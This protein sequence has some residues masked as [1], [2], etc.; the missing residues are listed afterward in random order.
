MVRKSDRLFCCIAGLLFWM[1]CAE[2]QMV[3]PYMQ[4][5]Y[6][7]YSPYSAQPYTPYGTQPYVS[8]S[9]QPYSQYRS[10][11]Y[12]SYYNYSSNSPY[13][14]PSTPYYDDMYSNYRL[15]RISPYDDPMRGREQMPMPV[16][17]RYQNYQ[18]PPNY[19]QLPNY[20]QFPNYQQPPRSPISQIPQARINRSQMQMEGA[21]DAN[22]APN[23]DDLADQNASDPAYD[24]LDF[25]FGS[26]PNPAYFPEN[27]LQVWFGTTPEADRQIRFRFEDD[28]VAASKGEYNHWRQTP[29]GTLAL[30]LL[31]D[32][33]T[34]R[35]YAD[36]PQKYAFD[37]MAKGLVLEAIQ[38]KEDLELYPIERAFLYLPL[39]H[40][41]DLRTQNLSV[42][43]YR[44]LVK[45]APGPLKDQMAAFLKYAQLHRDQIARFGRFPHRNAL[46]GRKSTPQ[47]EIF[48]KQWSKENRK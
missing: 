42:S 31:L 4:R 8:Y 48:L 24:I 7:P 33:F 23:A 12:P 43:L 25:W 26:L 41:E 17:P 9:G 1:N 47:E 6:S 16:I 30:V 27:Q 2:A 10:R 20:Q 45:E 38:K 15:P 28:I 21:E 13:S 22:L 32:Q 37:N 18:Q 46:L 29:K 11:M 40:A 44:Q 39:Q 14:V 5:Y 34:R 3:N 36:K 35:I 19:Q